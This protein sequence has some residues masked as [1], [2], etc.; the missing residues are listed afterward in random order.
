MFFWEAGLQPTPNPCGS[1]QPRML[2]CTVPPGLPKALLR[3]TRFIAKEGCCNRK[4]R[5]FVQRTSLE[6]C[7]ITVPWGSAPATKQGNTR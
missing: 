2:A 3:L 5:V 1:R 7:A 4:E 6:P